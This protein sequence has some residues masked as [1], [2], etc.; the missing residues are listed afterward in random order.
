MGKVKKMKHTSNFQISLDMIACRKGR[1]LHPFHKCF[2]TWQVDAKLLSRCDK[3]DLHKATTIN[4]DSIKIRTN[5]SFCQQRDFIIPIVATIF[6]TKNHF[7]QDE[8]QIS[9]V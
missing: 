6:G 3:P 9:V 5:L 7:Y 4:L 1:I 2:C 8:K